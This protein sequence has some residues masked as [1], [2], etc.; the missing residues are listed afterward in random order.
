MDESYDAIVL[1]TG[2]TECILSGLLSCDGKKVLHM[3]RNGYYGGDS[4]SVTL[5]Q[6]YEKFKDGAT[7]PR[8]TPMRDLCP[9]RPSALE[10]RERRVPLNLTHTRS[11]CRAASTR[12]DETTTV[13]IR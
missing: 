13:A 2:L 12:N 9:W 11:S 5:T 8:P 1:G 10:R 4:A 6:L 7:P 3:D